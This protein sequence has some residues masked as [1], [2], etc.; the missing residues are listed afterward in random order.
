MKKR[1]VSVICVFIIAATCLT[2]L[3]SLCSAADWTDILKQLP[4]SRYSF[5]DL[6]N[7]GNSDFIVYADHKI[8]FYI[9]NNGSYDEAGAIPHACTDICKDNDSTALAMFEGPLPTDYKKYILENGEIKATDVPVNETEIKTDYTKLYFAASSSHIYNNWYEAYKTIIDQYTGITEE[10][11]RN[12]CQIQSYNIPERYKDVNPGSLVYGD[13]KKGNY[14]ALKDI[15]HNGIP[16]LFVT[17]WFSTA[18]QYSS[19]LYY[20]LNICTF[21]KG[22]LLR[23]TGYMSGSDSQ[24]YLLSTDEIFGIDCPGASVY[25]YVLLKLDNGRFEY[26][27]RYE[28]VEYLPGDTDHSQFSD[29]SR[30][31]LEKHSGEVVNPDWKPISN[32][33]NE[34]PVRVVLNGKEVDF[35]GQR[36]F[37]D[38]ESNTTY[39]PMRTIFEAL[40]AA[41][42]WDAENR[43]V[44]ARKDGTEIKITLS[45]HNASI[46]GESSYIADPPKLI[47]GVTVVPLRFVS[48]ALGAEVNWD[49]A[50]R[51]VT[52]EG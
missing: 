43:S 5:M 16:E 49:G 24:T 8:S 28:P 18:P 20:M 13:D 27:D 48:E 37:I 22:L 52:I 23:Y 11:I 41:V 33:T 35:N 19:E 26:S 30:A 40:G 36:A 12:N 15:D 2:A 32:F 17:N 38:S 51:T 4:E 50:A 7:D 29:K 1:I 6:N 9:N 10:R 42:E 14:Y 31:M 39:V 47:D 34:Q 44:T 45:S 21:Y 46:N 3:P 25:S